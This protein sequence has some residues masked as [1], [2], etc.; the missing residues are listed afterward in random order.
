MKISVYLI[1]WSLSLSTQMLTILFP[2]QAEIKNDKLKVRKGAETQHRFTVQY[3]LSSYSLEDCLFW[4]A[5]QQKSRNFKKSL[6]D[7]HCVMGTH[8][9]WWG[10]TLCG[11]DTDYFMG[12]HNKCWGHTSFYGDRQYVVGTHNHMWG[13]TFFLCY[14]RTN[15]LNHFSYLHKILPTNCL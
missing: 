6:R 5:S 2:V 14:I 11:G 4:C 1:I 8:I 12:T 15:T 13:R 10:Q 3:T 7:G 9:I